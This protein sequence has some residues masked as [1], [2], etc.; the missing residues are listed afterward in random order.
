MILRSGLFFIFPCLSYFWKIVSSK[1]TCRSIKF[2][3]TNIPYNYSE[4]FAFEKGNIVFKGYIMANVVNI[5]M[6]Q[7][8]VKEPVLFLLAV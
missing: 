6:K 4:I 7:C 2:V 8:Q 5:S 1:I 3:L